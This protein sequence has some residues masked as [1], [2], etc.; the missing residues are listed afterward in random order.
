MH[1]TPGSLLDH[2]VT[3]YPKMGQ[4]YTERGREVMPPETHPTSAGLT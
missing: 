4:D 2:L 1:E 3:S